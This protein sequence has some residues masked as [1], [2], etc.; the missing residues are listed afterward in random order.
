MQTIYFSQINNT[1][2]NNAFLPYSVGML[3]SY[4][5]SHTDI[6]S[7]YQLGGM[8]FLREPI[9]QAAGR[10]KDPHVFAVSC[11][12]WNW[13][14]NQ[15]LM[16]DT[17]RRYPN[18]TIII[19]GPEAPS[20]SNGF[21]ETHPYVDF[22]VHDEG[23]I[24]FTELLRAL[25][26]GTDP[27]AVAGISYRHKGKTQKTAVRTRIPELAVLPSPYLDGTFDQIVAQYP[28][29]DWH[30]SQET[31]RG[32]PYSCTFCDWGSAVYTKVRSFDTE[33][34]LAELEW[35][36]T[37]K[38]DLLYNC[39]ANYG[40]LKR[41]IQLTE[42]LVETKLRYG[43]YPNKFRASY[44]KKSDQR[45]FEISR[46]LNDAGMSKGVTL[47]MQSMD[48]HTLDVIKRK[49]IAMD[50]FKPL[51]RQY[52]SAG[53]PTYTEIIMGLPG[54][55][56]DSFTQGLETLLAGGQ[57]D[58]LNIYLCMVLRNSEMARPEYVEQHGIVTARIPL[59]DTHS[60]TRSDE[61]V[62]YHDVIIGTRTLDHNQWREMVMISWLIQSLHCLGLTQYLAMDYYRTYANYMGFYTQ[63]M[64]D[65]RGRSTVLGKQIDRIQNRLAAVMSGETDWGMRDSRFGPINWPSEELTFLQIKSDPA[66]FYAE[67][68]P[69]L[70]TWMQPE[71]CEQAVDFQQR[72]I[73]GPHDSRDMIGTYSFDLVSM[74]EAISR[75]ERIGRIHGE[76]TIRF[77]SDRYYDGDMETYAREI[78]WY[79]RKQARC[80]K[81]ISREQD[82]ES[83]EMGT[84]A[85][86][87]LPRTQTLQEATS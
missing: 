51:V 54:E 49:N 72:M 38:I 76:T 60:S 21:L 77:S 80:K 57:H 46:L 64:A 31:H 58:N 56:F 8:L 53:I 87:T 24:T 17:K 2:G 81:K 26:D 85:V 59:V 74:M 12:L 1:F 86:A 42:R 69:F 36:G 25:R 79:G 39:D 65:H 23:E 61:I 35:F 5:R 10:I 83:N 29:I 48:S 7:S 73:Q 44:A 34:L 15:Q 4:A 66:Q 45:V 9:W 6:A 50:D 78:V 67:L 20:N 55:T 3:W 82:H 75:G 14:Y 37:R 47:S 84:T 43:G 63:L 28:E 32:C 40:L 19:G 70:Q 41:D 62:E 33:R 52:K 13:N 27:A 71:Y 30:A 18:V 16:I 11:Y 68:I 22:I